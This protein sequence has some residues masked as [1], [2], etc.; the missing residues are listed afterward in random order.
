MAIK[1]IKIDKGNSFLY[2]LR[3]NN[4]LKLIVLN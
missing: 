2:P 3:E 4:N 1:I